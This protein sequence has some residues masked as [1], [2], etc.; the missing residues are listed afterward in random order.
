MSQQDILPPMQRL[1][2]K[3]D[4]AISEIMLASKNLSQFDVPD[5]QTLKHHAEDLVAAG[6]TVLKRLE[7]Y[8]NLDSQSYTKPVIEG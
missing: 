4:R 1:T 8:Q 3:L 5:V 6:Q 7:K 2:G